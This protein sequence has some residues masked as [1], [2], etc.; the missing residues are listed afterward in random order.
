MTEMNHHNLVFVK[1]RRT[2]SGRPLKE[3]ERDT[4]EFL[5]ALGS[6][7][8]PVE[9]YST[10]GLKS[11]IEAMFWF[12]AASIRSIQDHLAKVR[13][14]AFGRELDIRYTLFGMK[15]ESVYTKGRTKQDQ[16]ID[17]TERLPYLVVYP[18][19]K[20]HEWHALDYDARYKMMGEHVGVAR[21]HKSVRQLLLYAY[22]VDDHEFIV[23]YE[24]ER[25]EDFQDLVID[26]RSTKGRAYTK[27]DLPIFTCIRRALPH[28][29]EMLQ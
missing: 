27:N 26:L 28:L 16:A 4:S 24:M 29:V 13:G 8:V 12:R 1:R 11:G 20:T 2:A 5:H 25:L 19:T 3:R 23:S 10:L 22:G 7:D 9:G 21:K 14:T 17:E 15:R 18:F 6:K